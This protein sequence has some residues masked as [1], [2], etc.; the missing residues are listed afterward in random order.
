MKAESIP[1][2]IF[3]FIVLLLFIPPNLKAVDTRKIAVVQNKDVLESGD[4]QVIDNFVEETVREI[5]ETKDFT[6]VSKIRDDFITNSVSKKESAQRQYRNQFI[7]SAVN[8]IS[9]AFKTSQTLEPE[10]RFR[11]VIN[12]MIVI[13]GIHDVQLS[14]LVLDKLDDGNAAVRY[15]AVKCFANPEVIKQLNDTGEN[16]SLSAQVISRIGKAIDNCT[17]MLLILITNFASELNNPQATE[18]LIRIA[19]LRIKQYAQWQVKDELTDAV[20]LKSLFNKIIS[21]QGGADSPRRFGQLYSYVFQRY[22]S[23]SANLSEF[24]K[25]NLVT[26]MVEIEDKCIRRLLGRQTKIREAIEK[27]DNTA[28]LSEHDN[29]L[30]NA[31]TEGKLGV[32]L[33]FLYRGQDGREST[34]PLALPPG[35]AIVLI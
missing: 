28:L 26:V 18:L 5:V 29:L 11:V 9:Q 15:W 30:G 20:V 22:L 6:T 1:A 2:K 10:I 35:G 13:E 33:N 21:N 17:D 34:A 24:H 7:K 19:D 12:L 23:G 25:Q 32:K 3:V 27:K 4:F 31:N 14:T 8:H 16:S